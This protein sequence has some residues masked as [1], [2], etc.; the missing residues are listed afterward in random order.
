MSVKSPR[1][2]PME[3]GS[4]SEAGMH[5]QKHTAKRTLVSESPV[6]S[7]AMPQT[8]PP[9]GGW[10]HLVLSVA[11]SALGP[12]GRRSQA[13][14]PATRVLRSIHS[15]L[16]FFLARPLRFSF[17]KS[18]SFTSFRLGCSPSTPSLLIGPVPARLS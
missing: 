6:S 9:A 14:S 2:R 10:E 12:P 5:P 4:G 11:E 8:E 17:S 1:D 13:P 15:T 18:P 3:K 7:P 16:S